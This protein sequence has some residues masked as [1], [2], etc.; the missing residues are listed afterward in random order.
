MDDNHPEGYR[1]IGAGLKVPKLLL[2]GIPSL[3]VVKARIEEV[4]K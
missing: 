1:Q 2:G 3:V 4:N